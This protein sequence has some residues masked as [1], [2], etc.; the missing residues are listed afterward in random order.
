MALSGS[1]A[2]CTPLAPPCCVPARDPSWERAV[3]VHESASHRLRQQPSTAVP[4]GGSVV[5]PHALHDICSRLHAV[6]WL[7]AAAARPSF[8]RHRLA[9]SLR[10]SHR[11]KSPC[12]CTSQL[13]TP[14]SAAVNGAFNGGSA[15]SP[16]ATHGLRSILHAVAW[17]RAAAARAAR[18]WHRLAASLRVSHRENTP[19]TCTCQLL[20]ASIRSRHRSLLPLLTAC[21]SFWAIVEDTDHERAGDADSA[22]DW[23]LSR[24][25]ARLHRL[26]Q[27]Q[28]PPSEDSSAREWLLVQE[29]VHT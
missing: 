5:P 9:A 17:L 1:S 28:Q 19:C 14:P 25:F 26:H 15:I 2:S 3:H 16:H 22:H 23:C 7:S 20:T 8:P 10:V 12:T 21:I 6:A 4:P 27:P 11:G 24:L 18:S 13:L 29:Y